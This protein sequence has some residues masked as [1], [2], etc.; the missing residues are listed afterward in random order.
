[1]KKVLVKIAATE[2][3]AAG[4]FAKCNLDRGSMTLCMT[5]ALLSSAWPNQQKARRR[6]K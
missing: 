6:A 3:M 1:M 5:K 4:L 2:M